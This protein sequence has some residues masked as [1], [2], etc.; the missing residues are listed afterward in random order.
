MTPD[1]LDRIL[2]SGDVIE[3]SSGLT[4]AVM[5]AVREQAAGPPPLPFPWVRFAAG[6]VA[7]GVLAA[8]GTVLALRVEPSIAA[9]AG[10]LASRVAAAPEAGYA[11][12]AALLSI[13]IAWLPRLFVRV[14]FN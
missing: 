5:D 1:E 8:S 10:S 3:P 9:M 11:V 12:M 7:C 14:I 6:L 13:G 4:K 2:C